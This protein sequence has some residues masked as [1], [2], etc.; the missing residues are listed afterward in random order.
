MA[1]AYRLPGESEG[2]VGVKAPLVE[3]V[4]E[5]G[6]ES[7]EQGVGDEASGQHALGRDQEP[8]VPGE[9]ALEAHLPT[10]LLAG[11][12]ATLLR[13][14][15]GQGARRDATRLEQD[16]RAGLQQ[17]RSHASR[18]PG[19]RLGDQD[20]AAMLGDQLPDP[21]QVRVDGKGEARH[22]PSMS[23]ATAL[24]VPGRGV[25]SWGARARLTLWEAAATLVSRA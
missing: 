8:R 9:A 15:P 14:S 7:L 10:D 19:A 12:P 23:A 17:G 5:D 22:R 4:E 20:Q 1:R 16:R 6:R 3:L 21:G 11:R 25:G 24:S 2:E 13:D 18:L